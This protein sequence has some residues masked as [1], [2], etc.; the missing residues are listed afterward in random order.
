[1]KKMMEP[2][3]E[4]QGSSIPIEQGMPDSYYNTQQMIEAFKKEDM[5]QFDNYKL[6]MENENIMKEFAK[7]PGQIHEPAV[8]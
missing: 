3:N 6:K 7:T 1:M 8:L 4:E 2:I 5:F